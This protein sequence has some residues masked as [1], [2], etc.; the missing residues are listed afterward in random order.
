[1][2]K[3]KWKIKRG[4]SE[5]DINQQGKA[6]HIMFLGRQVNRFSDIYS[7]INEKSLIET[8]D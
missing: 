2:K 8:Y 5:I 3:K 1:M 6:I 4:Y 7:K